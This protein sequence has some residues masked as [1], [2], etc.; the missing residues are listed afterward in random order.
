MIQWPWPAVAAQ[1]A[2]W[3][4]RPESVSPSP[5]VDR[6]TAVVHLRGRVPAD[7]VRGRP[8]AIRSRGQPPGDRRAE[9]PGVGA[10]RRPR[11]AAHPP[12]RRQGGRSSIS[13]L[14]KLLAAGKSKFKVVAEPVRDVLDHYKDRDK[15]AVF[16]SN[17]DCVILA[18]VA[19][20]AGQRGPAGSA[21][22]QHA[23]PGLRPGHDRR[24]GQLRRRRLAEHAGRKGPA[25]RFARSSRS[26]CRARAAWCSS[27]TPREMADGNFWQKKIAKL[28]IERLGPAD[29]VGVI[30]FDS[31]C[32]WHIPLAGGRR[33]PGGAAGPGRQA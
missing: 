19:G 15:L 23:R 2:S 11:P 6:R 7:M 5:A 16:L 8:T 17:F 21:P 27:C 20:R 4:C 32:K 33:Q 12:S 28:A 18:N 30:D 9:Q 29:E 3:S 26:R 1:A 10:R 14:D 13:S 31:Q 24:A 22:Q 25:G